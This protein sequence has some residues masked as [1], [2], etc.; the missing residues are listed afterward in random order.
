M[1]K[2]SS[3]IPFVFSI[4]LL[5]ALGLVLWQRQTIYDWFRLRGYVPSAQIVALADA[6]TMND[7]GRHI[8]YVYHPSLEDK[9]SFNGH[10]TNNE[11]SIVLG[12]YVQHRGIYVYDVNDPRLDGIEEVTAAHEMLHAAY[13]RLDD[14]ERAHIDTLTAQTLANLDNTRIHDTVERYRQRD[15]SVVPNELHSIL[16]TEVRELPKELEDYYKRYFSNRAAIVALSE[17]YEQAFT[18]RQNKIAEY[19]SQLRSLQQQINDLQ[20]SLDAQEQSLDVE[21]KRLDSMRSHGQ[22]EAYNAAVPGF[23]DQVRRYNAD[24]A[25]ARSL[26]DQYNQVV[27]ARNALAIE[28]NELIK[29]I[30]SRPSTIETQ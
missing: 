25:R 19:D 8:F 12:C 20:A 30:D 4:F 22:I 16:A 11:S 27:A 15:A 3:R 1:E 13:D 6:T 28:E 18:D 24:V 29:A 21:R 5:L 23:N 7:K 17:Q 26:I 14:D 9:A 10:C 2:S